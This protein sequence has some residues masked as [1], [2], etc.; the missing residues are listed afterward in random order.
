MKKNKYPKCKI[1]GKPVICGLQIHGKC[2]RE[3]YGVPEPELK[4][5]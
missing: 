1:C 5:V 3:A 2:W 4:V